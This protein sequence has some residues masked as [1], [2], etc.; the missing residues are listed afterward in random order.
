MRC[1]KQHESEDT[2]LQL[3]LSPPIFIIPEFQP[4]HQLTAEQMGLKFG[5]LAR[6]SK[7]RGCNEVKHFIVQAP[8]KWAEIQDTTGYG[9]RDGPYLVDE[10]GRR[11][12]RY[13]DLNNHNSARA[14]VLCRFAVQEWYLGCSSAGNEWLWYVRKTVGGEASIF[15]YPHKHA[16][17]VFEKKVVGFVDDGR[18]ACLAWLKKNYP[19]WENP[20]AYWDNP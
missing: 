16:P 17:V 10:L 13:S 8:E 4:R 7:D 2:A 9:E 19:D 15:R 20:L 18:D 5:P 3:H 1:G 6:I 12:V 11:R 14:E